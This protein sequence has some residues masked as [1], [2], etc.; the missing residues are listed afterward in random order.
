MPPR[1]S[2]TNE[3]G[4]GGF[5]HQVFD[6]GRSVPKALTSAVKDTIRPRSNSVKSR[7]ILVA[8]WKQP[9]KSK[10]PDTPSGVVPLA[11][12]SELSRVILSSPNPLL[13]WQRPA[14]LPNRTL[15]KS[16]AFRSHRE[17]P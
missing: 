14:V 3:G 6:F 15:M 8:T 16:I 5:G 13:Y 10:Y 17:T 11:T 9:A 1:S 7:L 4:S 12:A 2:S